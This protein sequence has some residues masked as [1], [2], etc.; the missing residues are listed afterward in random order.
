[1]RNKQQYLTICFNLRIFNLKIE[2]GAGID[3][4]RLTLKAPAFSYVL[5]TAFLMNEI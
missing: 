4:E 1:M 3:R 5:M 2:L